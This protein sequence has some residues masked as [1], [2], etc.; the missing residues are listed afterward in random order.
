MCGVS[1]AFLNLFRICPRKDEQWLTI[2]E[3]VQKQLKSP[4]ALSNHVK[5][6]HPVMLGKAPTTGNPGMER[7]QS[8]K[9]IRNLSQTV[10]NLF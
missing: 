10:S 5:K 9:S 2:S 4:G 7:I 6:Y 8:A 3:H 1:A